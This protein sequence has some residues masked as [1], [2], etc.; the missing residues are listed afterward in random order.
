LR[1]AAGEFEWYAPT[2]ADVYF[3]YAVKGDQPMA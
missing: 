2:W 3:R 1:W